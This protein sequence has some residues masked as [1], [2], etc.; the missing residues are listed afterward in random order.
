MK[1]FPCFYVNNKDILSAL[2]PVMYIDWSHVYFVTNRCVIKFCRHVIVMFSCMLLVYCKFLYT[3]TYTKSVT[4]VNANIMRCDN[5]LI[6][7]VSASIAWSEMP[8]QLVL[9]HWYNTYSCHTCC[10]MLWYMFFRSPALISCNPLANL[11]IIIFLL[12][13]AVVYIPLLSHW[14]WSC[15]I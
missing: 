4:C 3:G 14:Y 10:S 2:L 7:M 11:L 13:A 8:W 9:I 1:C 15:S 5:Y 6:L 12:T